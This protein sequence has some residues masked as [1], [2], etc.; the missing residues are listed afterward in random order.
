MTQVEK[1]HIRPVVAL[2]NECFISICEG[3]QVIINQS[4]TEALSPGEGQPSSTQWLMMS[5]SLRLGTLIGGI[6]VEEA[7]SIGVQ[8]QHH[9]MVD[10]FGKVL[11]S[12]DCDESRKTEFMN[13]ARQNLSH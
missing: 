1:P 8:R 3:K 4:E 11:A 10:H 6:D 13:W 2:F 5:Y 7:T 9:P 12:M